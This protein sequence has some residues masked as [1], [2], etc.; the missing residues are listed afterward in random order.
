ML[1]DDCC[2]VTGLRKP[3]FVLLHLLHALWSRFGKV[4]WTVLSIFISIVS[5][6]YVCMYAVCMYV[7]L[8]VIFRR[9]GLNQ[10]AFSIKSFISPF[11]SIISQYGSCLSVNE[12]ENGFVCLVGLWFAL[13]CESIEI[14]SDGFFFHFG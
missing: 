14:I 5:Y 9:E 2:F 4:L 13:E 1:L 7:N 8:K 3:L 10:N 11:V 6:S 12:F